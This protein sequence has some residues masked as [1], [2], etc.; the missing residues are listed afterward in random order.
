VSLEFI[1]LYLKGGK[2]LPYCYQWGSVAYLKMEILKKNL[3]K[4]INQ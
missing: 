4:L 2:N 1:T 3:K